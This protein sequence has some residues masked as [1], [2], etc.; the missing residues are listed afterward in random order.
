MRPGA[1]GSFAARASGLGPRADGERPSPQQGADRTP[2]RSRGCEHSR[3]AIE[4]VVIDDESSSQSRYSSI[5]CTTAPDCEETNASAAQRWQ[6]RR[7][8]HP[9]HN[10]NRAWTHDSA[11]ADSILPPIAPGDA[12]NYCGIFLRGIAARTALSAAA[13]RAVMMSIGNAHR[14]TLRDYRLWKGQ[15]HAVI[16]RASRSEGCGNV[17]FR[18]WPAPPVATPGS[19][20]HAG[21]ATR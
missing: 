5:S 12:S 21:R 7:T 6:I 16:V 13:P 11:A 15:P 20:Q 10:A 17:T 14:L 19:G 9:S 3:E 18:L 8:I 1:P 4:C 2:S